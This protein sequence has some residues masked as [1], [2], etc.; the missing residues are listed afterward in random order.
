MSAQASRFKRLALFGLGLTTV[1]SGLL[2]FA[3]EDIAR[4]VKQQL[5]SDMFVLKDGDAFDPGLPI[6]TR[7]PALSARLD[8][9]PVTDVSRLVG[10]KGMIFIAVRSVDW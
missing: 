10:D 4:A 1:V 9:M 5:T 7:F 3:G 8:A 6:G 2:W